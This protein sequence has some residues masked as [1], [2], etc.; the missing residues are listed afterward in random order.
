M[1]LLAKNVDFILV[2]RTTMEPIILLW[3]VFFLVMAFV[4]RRSMGEGG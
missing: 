2:R 4:M 3:F 1:V